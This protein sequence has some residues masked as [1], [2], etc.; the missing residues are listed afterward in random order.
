MARVVHLCMFTLLSNMVNTLLSIMCRHLY[1]VLSVALLGGFCV[2][3]ILVVLLMD[4]V[5]PCMIVIILVFFVLPILLV[6]LLPE[7]M[8][9][10]QGEADQGDSQG[11]GELHSDK[12]SLPT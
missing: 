11:Q 9:L 2:T 12:E 5:T 8:S 10:Y 1:L 6:L 7:E 4:C 3:A